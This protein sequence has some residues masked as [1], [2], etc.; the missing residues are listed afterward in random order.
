LLRDLQKALLKTGGGYA[1]IFGPDGQQLHESLS[2]DEEGLVY[3]EID[4]GLISVAKAVADPAGHYSRPDVTQLVL[5]RS[6]RRAVVD[7]APHAGTTRAGTTRTESAKPE[8]PKPDSTQPESTQE[9]TAV[10]EPRDVVEPAFRAM[11]EL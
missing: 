2:A 11:A 9:I 1:R 3:G 7:T 6:P 4:L 10:P 5:N 8:T